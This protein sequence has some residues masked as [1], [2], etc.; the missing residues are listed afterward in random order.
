MRASL[1][2]GGMS[3]DKS[4]SENGVRLLRELTEIDRLVSTIVRVTVA[5]DT[6]SRL[7]IE[8][9]H[10]I[11]RPHTPVLEACWRPHSGGRLPDTAKGR[12]RVRLHR[13][14][15]YRRVADRD[16]EPAA[17]A[18]G[19]M[20][21]NRQLP[22]DANAD[23]IVCAFSKR[24]GMLHARLKGATIGAHPSACTAIMRGRS[25]PRAD[26]LELRERLHMPIRPV[27]PPVG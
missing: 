7:R 2:P 18:H 6:F 11:G 5:A 24:G 25:L 12:P 20:I 19:R 15:P 3:L 16:R 13:L 10:A 27:P 14:P 1:S 22:A 17:L 4:D 23:A 8:Q 21:G 9:H 26:G